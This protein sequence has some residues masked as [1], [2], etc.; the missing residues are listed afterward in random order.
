MQ[1]RPHVKS[2]LIFDIPK[3][4][5]DGARA[6]REAT[7]LPTFPPGVAQHMAR[8]R[9]EVESARAKGADRA[10]RQARLPLATLARRGARRGRR[11]V[12][13]ERQQ[14]RAAISVPQTPFGV[15]EQANRTR[16]HRLAAKGHALEGQGRAGSAARIDVQRVEFPRERPDHAPGPTVERMRQPI[17]RLLSVCEALPLKATRE[18]EQHHGD[19]PGDRG[20][21]LTAC[22]V[23]RAAHR[24]AGLGCTVTDLIEAGHGRA[25]YVRLRGDGGAASCL[26]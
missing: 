11:Q 13:G 19:G 9:I 1:E 7:L 26:I 12:D 23:E 16:M 18:S 8:A 22:R 5:A 24:E 20:I 2:R 21:E 3:L 4:R 14:K 17:P 15:N 10:G 25:S 6:P